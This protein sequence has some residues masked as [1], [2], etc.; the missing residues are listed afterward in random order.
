VRSWARGAYSVVLAF[1]LLFAS[2]GWGANLSP[3]ELEKL[4]RG[5]LVARELSLSRS[6]RP[7]AGLSY[8]VVD[9]SP[10]ELSAEL[11]EG[12]KLVALLPYLIES[13]TIEDGVESS[14]YA[15]RQGALGVTGRYFLSVKWGPDRLG[16]KFALDPRRAH[17]LPELW[18]YYRLDPF[19]GNRTLVTFAIAFRLPAGLRPFEGRVLDAALTTPLRLR[20]LVP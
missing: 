9:A 7:R 13:Q 14:T 8:A 1:I 2:P 11:R 15:I 4:G 6:P 17:D 19:P 5:E 12:Q 20:M 10:R 18:G 3:A 16:G